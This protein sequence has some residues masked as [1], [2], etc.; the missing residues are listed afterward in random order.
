MVWFVKTEL[1]IREG[2][3]VLQD[4]GY[5]ETQTASQ[6]GRSEN[7]G[8]VTFEAMVSTSNINWYFP[9][10]GCNVF[11]NT[12]TFQRFS[13]SRESPCGYCILVLQ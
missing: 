10:N 2:P 8:S 4:T 13:S 5:V 11:I 6:N 7:A 12:V 3:G 1:P 9:Y